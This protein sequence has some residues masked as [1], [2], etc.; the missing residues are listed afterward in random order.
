MS[1][2][3]VVALAVLAL[4]A[5]GALALAIGALR[6]PRRAIRV[7]GPGVVWAAFICVMNLFLDSLAHSQSHD[8]SY[9]TWIRSGDF[10]LSFNLLVDRLSIFM[11]LVITGVGGLIVTYAVGYMEHETDGSYARFFAYM[12]LFVLSML[13]LVLA[14]N[15][16]F[17]IVGWAGVGLSSYLLIGFYY[18]RNSAV[19][20]ARKAFVM[21]V[22][23]DIGLILAAFAIFLTYHAVNFAGVFQRLGGRDS[24]TLELIAFLLLVGGIAKSAQL[25]L[26]TWLPDAME[27][28]TPVSALI[29]AATMVT[30]GVYLVGRMHPIYDVALYAHGTVAVIGAAS[31]LFAA[32]VALVQTDIKRV[33]AYSTMSQIGYMFLGVGVG[34]YAAAFF[35][36]LSHAFFKALLFMSAGNVIHAMHDEQ[37]MR[38]FGGLWRQLRPTSIAF[39]IGSLSLV[40]IIPLVGFF[41]KELILGD[42][43]SKPG[44]S[45]FPQLM[46]LV[47]FA[48]AILTGFYT[49]RMWWLAFWGPPSPDRAVLEPH[50]APRVMLWP[51]L[52]LA[53]C[54]VLGGLLQTSALGSQGPKSIEEFLSPAVG[55]LG[56]EANPLELLATAATLLL[57]A[58]AFWLA[59]YFYVEKRF[60]PWSL[61]FPGAQQVLEHKYYFDEAYNAVFVRGMDTLARGGERLLENPIFD[62]SVD[63]VGTGAEAAAGGLSLTQTGFFRNYAFVF[64]AGVV[65]AGGLLLIRLA[66]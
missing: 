9:W 59:R 2:L 33:L 24:F 49:G 10:Q 39:L 18:W 5:L 7:I 50:E 11:C 61:R 3:Q 12:D 14:G 40:G 36:L 31:A 55:R 23:G 17:L 63:G 56:W 34:A 16:L 48:T 38:R 21:N 42:A 27:G 66:T 64:V 1:L 4:P 53:G 60:S 45:G 41:S 57:G 26:H 43:F 52:I 65:V 47:G 30:A 51:V 28:P 58:G 19:V 44:G 13:V 46:W 15:F 32:T 37:D 25:P 62:G 20:A 8:F 54:T 35:H 6:I 22:I 29:H